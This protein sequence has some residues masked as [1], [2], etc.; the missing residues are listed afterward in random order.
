[1]ASTELGLLTQLSGG[2]NDCIFRDI[3][4]V[5][6]YALAGVRR[7]IGTQKTAGNAISAT[8]PQGQVGGVV[9]RTVW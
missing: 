3:V 6:L 1:M 8:L 4:A 5:K 9:G 7:V 2:D